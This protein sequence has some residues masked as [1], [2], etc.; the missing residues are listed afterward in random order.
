MLSVLK[1]VLADFIAFF[2]LQSIR[3]RIRFVVALVIIVALTIFVLPDKSNET[4]LAIVSVPTIELIRVGDYNNSNT[5]TLLGEVRSVSE[6]LLQ[7]QTS[8][9][10]SNIPVSLGQT[11]RTGDTIIK[12]DSATQYAALLQAEGAY[13]AA[14]AAAASSDVSVFGSE[15]NLSL[16]FE[17][18]RTTL[19]NTISSLQNIFYNDLDEIFADPDK[20]YRNSGFV[21]SEDAPYLQTLKIVYDRLVNSTPSLSVPIDNSL[22][23]AE[24]ISEI[25]NVIDDLQLSVNTLRSLIAKEDYRDTQDTTASAYLSVLSS[26]ASTLNTL[27]TSVANTLRSIESAQ[28]S[29]EKARLGGTYTDG[30]TANAQVKQALGA[31]KAAEAN[32]NKTIIRSP[33]DGVI[34]SL[35]VQKGNF[36]SQ[37]AEVAKITND[38][39][40]EIIVYVNEQE[41]E[42]L[43]V[44]QTVILENG[45]DGTISSISPSI[46]SLTGKIEVRITSSDSGILSG[47]TA[48]VNIDTASTGKDTGV[49][50]IPLNAIKFNGD[51]PVVFTVS[52]ENTLVSNPVRIG[53]PHGS[54]IVIESG[55]TTDM[56]IITDA[57]GRTAGEI[58]NIK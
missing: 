22:L 4:E 10:I 38:T 55:L 33:I 1:S 29:L 27:E 24:G 9:Q 13:E 26:T 44:G 32:Y 2:S 51:E 18:S 28:E 3:G 39:A 19:E 41:Q 53:R 52:E 31:L 47:S 6:V 17:T 43:E 42:N 12:L 15:K 20:T 40:S 35:P 21:S 58:V 14:L 56:V 16:A 37:N 54:D 7:T 50:S 11:V 5:L 25:T 46:S 30:S 36:L 45:V 8:G 57:R 23:T 34:A 49:I 48:R